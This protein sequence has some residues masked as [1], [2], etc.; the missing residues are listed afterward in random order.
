MTVDVSKLGYFAVASAFPDSALAA[1]KAG[2]WFVSA[3]SE[4]GRIDTLDIY[5][6]SQQ[7][8]EGRLHTLDAYALSQ[9]KEDTRLHTLN[10]YVV[11]RPIIVG[12]RKTI[13]IINLGGGSGSGGS[14]PVGDKVLEGATFQ[15]Q[16]VHGAAELA[17]ALGSAL[18]QSQTVSGSVSVASGSTV[19]LA[20]ALS[21]TQTVVGDPTETLNIAG[22]V[23]Q[24]QT[25]VGDPVNNIDI[26]LA[27]ALSQTQTVVGDPTETLNIVGTISQSQS[28]TLDSSEPV[29]APSFRYYRLNVSDVNGGTFVA[30]GELYLTNNGN[31]IDKSG[32]TFSASTTASGYPADNAFDNNPGS[33][34]ISTTY[35]AWL[36]VDFGTPTELD[37]YG[38]L[39]HLGGPDERPR[40]WTFEGSD[41]DSSW[42]VLDTQADYDFVSN[43][44]PG[45][46]EIATLPTAIPYRYWRLDMT[47]NGG[48]SF[49]VLAEV[50]LLRDDVRVTGATVTA[51]N[52]Y[53]SFFAASNVQD[54]NPS[55]IYISASNGTHAAMLDFDYGTAVAIDQL[56]L[57]PND[58]ND[59]TAPKDF[60][61]KA[62]NDGSTWVDIHA[63]VNWLPANRAEAFY[64]NPFFEQS[65]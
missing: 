35:P 41:D 15:S 9:Q 23:S 34:W 60:V 65:P 25:V 2:F 61:L 4:G 44:S 48:G 50:I 46:F 29:V 55:T 10:A 24:T 28:I 18:S 21:Q 7:V 54:G 17:L 42:T 14:T 22:I 43:D 53:D 40:Y 11:S 13:M 52:I 39:L 56:A 12:G 5:A 27:V 30:F 62:S 63:Q 64:F 20:V 51:S 19:D 37:Q 45:W 57:L 36:K 59:S 49:I 47:A 32:A 3:P 16:I 8:E 38:I 58:S 31:P 26:D 33:Y 6:L 1:S